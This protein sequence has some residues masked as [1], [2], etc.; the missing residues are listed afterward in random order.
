MTDPR[1]DNLPEDERNHVL[2]I[3]SLEEQFTR[4]P[5]KAD[6][7]DLTDISNVIIATFRALLV[8][9]NNTLK[10]LGKEGME[11]IVVGT[12]M[13]SYNIGRARGE[14]EARYQ[15][16]RAIAQLKP[17]VDDNVLDVVQV[18]NQAQS[19]RAQLQAYLNS[20]EED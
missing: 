19:V 10:S 11:D 4:M 20:L 12:T 17:I 2:N 1:I 8:N 9:P 13:L 6:G 16:E 15:I 3:K 7:P 5:E 18:Y 14:T